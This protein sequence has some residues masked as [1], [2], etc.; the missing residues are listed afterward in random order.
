M[1]SETFAD[2]D[3]IIHRIDPQYRILSAA[4]YSGV[5]AVAKDILTLSIAVFISIVILGFARL[6]YQ[7]V[8]KRLLV[9]SGFVFLI[10]LVM[11]VTFEG[12]AVYYI[13]P[14]PF[15][16]QGLRL[17]A[18]ITLKSIAIYLSFLALVS[19]VSVTNMGYALSRIGLPNKVVCLL[20]MTYRYFSVIEQEYQRLSRA[21]K[22]RAFRPKTNIHTYRTYAY[23]IG[24]LFVRASLRAGR[25]YNAMKCR[26]FK[27]IFYTL[28]EFPPHRRNTIFSAMMGCAILCLFIM[29]WGIH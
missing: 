26:G 13:G 29:E 19:T 17:S 25:V 14:I 24:M 6:N 15:Y 10:W 21:I 23:L 12:E 27:G 20:M 9:I 2:G 1:I 16:L 11:P 28:H 4:L 18:Q 22:I 7:Q 3:S 5:I 8:A